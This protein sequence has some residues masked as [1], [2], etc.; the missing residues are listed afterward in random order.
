M[1]VT[2]FPNNVSY[3]K[4]ISLE[5]SYKKLVDDQLVKST[6][7]SSMELIPQKRT[8][9]QVEKLVLIVNQIIYFKLIDFGKM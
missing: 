9:F 4:L 3:S 2:K 8:L 1:R 6:F 7:H 5:E